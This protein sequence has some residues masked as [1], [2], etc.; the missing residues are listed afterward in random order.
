MAH[1][2]RRSV[3]LIWAISAAGAATRADDTSYD[4]VVYGGTS[5]AVTAVVAD[6]AVQDVSYPALRRR[7]LAEGQMINHEIGGRE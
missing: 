4:V 2:V 7:L 5:A 6:L 1:L 3:F